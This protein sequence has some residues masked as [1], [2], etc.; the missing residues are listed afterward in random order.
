MHVTNVDHIDDLFSYLQ[1]YRVA[2]FTI[3]ATLGF[4]SI[5]V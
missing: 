1:D 4:M 5:T 3:V 2:F